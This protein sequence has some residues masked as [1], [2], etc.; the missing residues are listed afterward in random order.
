MVSSSR[1]LLGQETRE[2]RCRRYASAPAHAAPKGS[3]KTGIENA[4]EIIR[5]TSARVDRLNRRQANYRCRFTPEVGNSMP[6]DTPGTEPGRNLAMDGEQ[7][8]TPLAA[9]LAAL[10]FRPK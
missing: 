9:V 1:R 5:G 2:K 6:G 3:R 10:G 8:R 7:H 4:T